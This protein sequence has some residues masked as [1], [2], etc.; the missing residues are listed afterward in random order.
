MR[1]WFLSTML[2][3]SI[4]VPCAAAAASYG[5]DC[6][7]APAAAVSAPT[8]AGQPVFGVFDNGVP[9]AL[10]RD[11]GGGLFV[12][13]FVDGR[14][15]PPSAR[16]GPVVARDLQVGD[17]DGDGVEDL[18]E[19]DGLVV[20][21]VR[22]IGTAFEAPRRVSTLPHAD[23][24]WRVGDFD[25]D[26]AF[27]IIVLN[28]RTGRVRVTEHALGK[29]AI[30]VAAGRWPMAYTFM[31]ADVD[32][33]GQDDAVGVDARTGRVRVGFS[34]AT[35]FERR[36][37]D[38]RIP[39]GAQLASADVTGDGLADLVF[40]AKGSDD[41]FV[42]RALQTDETT[43]FHTARRWGRW[44]RRLPL[45]TAYLNGVRAGLAARDPRT[46]RIMVALSRARLASSS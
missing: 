29:D 45:T 17:V 32:R 35:E 5:P 1:G 33:D 14:F 10:V 27:D 30:T 23:A 21:V 42:R 6:C 3:A 25:G 19:R 8:P 26:E 41:V 20:S 46:G 15:G 43:S 39:A 12:A 24:E 18:V 9:E 7:F 44:D 16:P 40:R 22:S 11:S 31:I 34:I 13:Q 4:G 36:H 2:V 28:R 38:W 37:A